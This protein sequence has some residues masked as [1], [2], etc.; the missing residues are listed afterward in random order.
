VNTGEIV[1][2][3]SFARLATAVAGD[4]LHAD[5]GPLGAVSFRFV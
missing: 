1:P 2:R 5:N 3:G 4:T